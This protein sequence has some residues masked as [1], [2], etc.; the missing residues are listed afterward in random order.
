MAETQ[1]EWT[2]ATW[3]PLPAARSSP[4]AAPI[5]MPWRWLSAGGHAHPEICRSD[6]Q[7][8]QRTVWN[9]VV[10]EDRDALVI[11][12]VGASRARFSLI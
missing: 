5:A 2:D 9:G 11:S 3:N 1:I 12:M 7:E 8:G 4:P 10:R 6:P